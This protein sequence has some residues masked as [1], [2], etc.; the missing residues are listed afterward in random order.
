MATPSGDKY[1]PPLSLSLSLSFFLCPDHV[2]SIDDYFSDFLQLLSKPYSQPTR[3]PRWRLQLKPGSDLES[4]LQD[5]HPSRSPSFATLS[6]QT[7]RSQTF[8]YFRQWGRNFLSP[9]FSWS[10]LLLSIG[11]GRSSPPCRS[12]WYNCSTLLIL[13]SSIWHP[14]D[15]LCSLKIIDAAEI[16]LRLMFRTVFS[17]SSL[18]LSPRT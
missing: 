3:S 14:S 16:L 10:P 1:C 6:M 2:L 13:R 5:V 12:W 17:L 9:L 7:H 4:P 11:L 15:P 8:F 18:S